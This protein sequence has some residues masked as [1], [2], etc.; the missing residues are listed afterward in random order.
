VTAFAWHIIYHIGKVELYPLDGYDDRVGLFA[1]SS[2]GVGRSIC[3]HNE[4]RKRLTVQP[5]MQILHVKT[6]NRCMLL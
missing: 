3:G 5:N 2:G 1:Q 6:L 4:E